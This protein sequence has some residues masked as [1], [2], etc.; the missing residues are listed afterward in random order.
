[1]G[2]RA[3][4]GRRRIVQ[5]ADTELAVLDAESGDVL[6]FP[7]PWPRAFGTATVSP[8]GDLAV[9]AGVHAV[10]AVDTSGATRWEV[11]HGCWSDVEC[12]E[13]HESFAEHAQDEDHARTDSGSAAF[14]A[15][16]K[17]VWSHVRRPVRAAEEEWLVID[18]A[19]GRVP[20][21]AAT[22]TVGSGSFPRPHPYG[23]Y[24]GLSVGEGDGDSPSL[25]G[26]WDGT[27]LT[28]ER[29]DGVLIQDVSP[30]GHHFLCT[31]PARSG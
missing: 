7:A 28:F 26:H 23:P 19:D 5:R 10:R 14:S 3:A 29:V 4:G 22:D 2:D 1:M 12:Y 15:D 11:R 30:S 18:A 6:R 17:L 24:M 9:F 20:G 27:R 8:G 21:R 25:W 16:G 13:A 31:D